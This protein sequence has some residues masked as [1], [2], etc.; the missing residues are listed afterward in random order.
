M[1]GMGGVVDVGAT[2]GTGGVEGAVWEAVEV[3]GAT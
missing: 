3:M 2:R 1:G